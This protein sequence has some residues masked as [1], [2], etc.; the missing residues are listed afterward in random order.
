MFELFDF[1]L[2]TFIFLILYIVEIASTQLFKI[3]LKLLLLLHLVI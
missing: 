1:F 2:F 3:S